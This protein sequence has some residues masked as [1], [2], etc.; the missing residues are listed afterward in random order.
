MASIVG[1]AMAAM[2]AAMG[3]RTSNQKAVCR[4]L[5][6]RDLSAQAAHS[7]R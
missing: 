2:V 1:L 4:L 3:I 7:R 6:L 5:A